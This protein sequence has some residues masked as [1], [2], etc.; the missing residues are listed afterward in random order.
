MPY[1]WYCFDKHLLSLQESINEVL[2][3]LVKEKGQM[4]SKA[5]VEEATDAL[6]NLIKLYDVHLPE[7]IF[8]VKSEDAKEKLR[9][10]LQRTKALA[11]SLAL[12]R[13]HHYGMITDSTI[14]AWEEAGR[15]VKSLVEEAMGTIAHLLE[16]EQLDCPKCEAASIFG[17]APAHKEDLLSEKELVEHVLSYL[18]KIYGVPKP[19]YDFLAEGVCAEEASACVCPAVG[20]NMVLHFTPK[21]VRPHIIAHEFYHYMANLKGLPNTEYDAEK[22][23]CEHYPGDYDCQVMKRF[24]NEHTHNHKKMIT[25]TEVGIIYGCSHIA[26]GV[27]RGLVEL[28]KAVGRALLKPHA[29]PSTWV[30]LGTSIVSPILA[31]TWLKRQ[32]AAALGLVAFGAHASTKVWD[33]VEEYAVAMSPGSSYE[34][35]TPTGTEAEKKK[36][37]TFED[38]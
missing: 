35:Y 36:G 8:Q 20:P 7:I 3:K 19:P 2:T 28:D 18:S 31:L 12:T 38:I 32:P 30:V 14:R 21:K 17:R 15:E 27:E 4:A 33:Y 1:S 5:V 16:K 13:V 26:K 22:F 23:A 37:V 6:A 11:H 29:R 9:S 25:Y 10:F 24:I 34:E